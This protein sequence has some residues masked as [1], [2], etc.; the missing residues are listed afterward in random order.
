ML[1]NSKINKVFRIY[2]SN[3]YFSGLLVIFKN[4]F[5][6]KHEVSYNDTFR[7]VHNYHRHCSASLMFATNKIMSFRERWRAAQWNIL[8]Q[9]KKSEN[10]IIKESF[11]IKTKIWEK[12]FR[13]LF[14]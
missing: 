13:N 14:K 3:I 6:N 5:F 1:C 10:L 8:K 4:C 2:T 11:N 9:F 12:Y 7:L